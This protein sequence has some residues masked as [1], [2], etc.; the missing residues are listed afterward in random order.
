[1]K[2]LL[3]L[4]SG[5]LI[6]ATSGFAQPT[7]YP[8]PE[9]NGLIFITHATIHVGN[10]NIINDGTIKINKGKIEKIGTNI[11]VPADVKVFDVKGKRYIRD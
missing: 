3:Y 8:A 6:F 4:L 9:N 1:M 7:V 11:P 5:I 10:G 2:K